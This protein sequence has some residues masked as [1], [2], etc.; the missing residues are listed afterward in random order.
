[1]SWT[2]GWLKISWDWFKLGLVH[3]FLMHNFLYCPPWGLF[4]N[5]GHGA[6][7]VPGMRLFTC[8]DSARVAKLNINLTE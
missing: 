8:S 5:G 1:M 3:G 6:I 7:R 4:R 2:A